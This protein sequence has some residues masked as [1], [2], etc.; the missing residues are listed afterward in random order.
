MFSVVVASLRRSGECGGCM[1]RRGDAFGRPGSHPPV[2]D[3]R[4][5]A[6]LFSSSGARHGA[7]GLSGRIG[8]LT[9]LFERE[10]CLLKEHRHWP[11]QNQARGSRLGSL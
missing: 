3:R 4:P 9:E 10:V 7:R 6:A 5:G 11:L 1:S 8:T 2:I